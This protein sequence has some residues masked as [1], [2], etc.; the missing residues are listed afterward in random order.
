M[1]KSDIIILHILNLDL[2]N[3]RNNENEMLDCLTDIILD[4]DKDSSTDAELT[5]SEAGA[6]VSLVWL[7]IS[8]FAAKLTR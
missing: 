1:D 5:N 2:K 6:L 4:F 8:H 3:V 7:S